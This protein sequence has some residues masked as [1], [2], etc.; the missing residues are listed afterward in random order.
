MSMLMASKSASEERLPRVKA[1]TLVLM[2]SRD[3][4]FKDPEA[5]A[6]WV[7]ESLRGSYTMIQQAG[8]YPQAE[9]PEVAGQLIVNFLKALQEPGENQYVSQS[10]IE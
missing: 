10:E 1:R 2:G 4:D 8:H 5:E 6:R 9:M 7:A 3:R